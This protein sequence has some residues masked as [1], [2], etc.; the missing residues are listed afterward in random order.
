MC[1]C[2]VSQAGELIAPLLARAQLSRHS[3][4]YACYLVPFVSTHNSSCGMPMHS[5]ASDKA[6]NGPNPEMTSWFPMQ[7][8]QKR[9]TPT[10]RAAGG[11]SM[12]EINQYMSSFS[13]QA[14]SMHP[15]ASGMTQPAGKMQTQTE[16]ANSGYSDSSLASSGPIDDQSGENDSRGGSQTGGSR[17]NSSRRRR[18]LGDTLA[19]F[20]GS[21]LLDAPTHTYDNPL[22]F[23]VLQGGDDDTP[24]AQFVPDLSLIHI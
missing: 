14:S 10:H 17:V 24:T 3:K 15:Q 6:G 16:S 1:R 13:Q 8:S 22:T 2:S 4:L 19:A 23:S 11:A 12:G 18:S 20:E 5:I 21:T 9:P 7:M